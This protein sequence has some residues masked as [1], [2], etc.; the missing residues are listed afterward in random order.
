MLN[1]D[2]Y[3]NIYCSVGDTFHLII[4]PD[5]GETFSPGSTLKFIVAQEETST[6]TIEKTFNL[7][8][9]KFEITL[10]S[11]EITTLIK[12]TYY[13]KMILQMNNT[14]ITQIS[15]LLKVKWGA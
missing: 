10:T 14:I 5:D 7:V 9:G 4:E 1:T 3:G 12:G 2:I 15:G 6:Y 8:D 13:Y 11:A